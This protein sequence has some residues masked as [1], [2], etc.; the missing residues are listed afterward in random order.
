MEIDQSYIHKCRALVVVQCLTLIIFSIGGYFAYTAYPYMLTI[1]LVAVGILVLALCVTST[2]TSYMQL[3]TCAKKLHNFILTGVKV[4]DFGFRAKV[5]VIN[6]D[7][8]E[9]RLYNVHKVYNKF[10]AEPYIDSKDQT[11]FVPMQIDIQIC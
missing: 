2:F 4:Q 6:S 1:E 5:T 8:E 9:V 3:V 7:A 10:I 11:L